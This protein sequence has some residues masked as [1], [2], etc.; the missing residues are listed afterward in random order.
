M[1]NRNQTFT[2]FMISILAIMTIIQPWSY[3]QAL[4]SSVTNNNDWPMFRNAVNNTGVNY[5]SD[6]PI[7]NN[8][9][10][11]F[12]TN[13]SIRSSPVIVQDR[14]YIATTNGN[15]YCLWSENGT[16]IW[17]VKLA[18]IDYSTP[19]VS[20]DHLVIG[21]L[22]GNIYCLNSTTGIELWNFSA[23]GDIQA[24]PVIYKNSVYI[25]S[26]DGNAY[27]LNLSTGELNW[28]ITTSGW[29]HTSSA[30]WNDLLFFGGCDGFIHAV[31]INGSSF[32][33]FNT[34]DYVVS[35]P[36]LELGKIYFGTHN[37][38]IYCLNATS[39]EVIW[40]N[41]TEGPIRSS[42]AVYENYII[43]ADWNKKIYGY[44]KTT[45]E[46]IWSFEAKDKIYSSPAIANNVL[47]IGSNDGMVY[48]L[49]LTNGSKIWEYT[50]A[51]AVES[52]PAI[53]NNRVYIGSSDGNL[54]CFG[55]TSI[56]YLPPR[57]NIL[58]PENNIIIL[59]KKVKVSGNVTNG[60]LPVKH[61][62]IKLNNN[63]WLKLEINETNHWEFTYNLSD[64]PNGIY[65]ISVRA[66]DG[67]QYSS[68]ISINFT[69]N[70]Q[71][72]DSVILYQ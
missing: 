65:K 36:V 72:P 26:Y 14:V 27:S 10:W 60:D 56:L 46:Q 15:L 19:A 33:D 68:E 67:G 64:Q 4:G 31:H 8:T 40:T 13:S 41:Q 30:I 39:K 66:F 57:V 52:S 20:G 7:N 17:R 1:V 45:G 11:V 32:W 25:N 37:N 21:S 53:S 34:E 63:P 62:E 5:N 24:S 28:N 6:I 47:V 42:P 69:L 12:S 48:C 2:F 3:L 59:E 55:E 70:Y 22:G 43:F 51:D 23:E 44:N 71:I 58:A 29:I 61:V 38:I 9:L 49:S 35:S 50:T 54:Y 18:R 16:E